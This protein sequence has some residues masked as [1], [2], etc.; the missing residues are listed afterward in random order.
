MYRDERMVCTAVSAHSSL[1][2]YNG[3]WCLGRFLLYKADFL[4]SPETKRK[5]QLLSAKCVHSQENYDKALRASDEWVNIY[6]SIRTSIPE[7]W[8]WVDMERII[9]HRE[10]GA[11]MYF[12][13][14]HVYTEDRGIRFLR[15]VGVICKK[16]H[17]VPP[18]KIVSSNSPPFRTNLIQIFDLRFRCYPTCVQRAMFYA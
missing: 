7:E 10:S 12:T 15:N 8:I 5:K 9:L 1:T 18:H 3:I 14:V 4:Y 17:G 11:C 2:F 16:L 6:Q 13:R